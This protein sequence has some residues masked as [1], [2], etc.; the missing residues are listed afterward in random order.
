MI[1]QFKFE[2]KIRDKDNELAK[3]KEKSEEMKQH[4]K[5]KDEEFEKLIDE[6]TS[7]LEL[8]QNL[9]AD[10]ANL[11]STIKQIFMSLLDGNKFEDV[12]KLMN[13]EDRV[14]FFEE[15]YKL[16]KEVFPLSYFSVVNEL[17]NVVEEKDI[18][19]MLKEKFTFEYT[20]FTQEYTL[21]LLKHLIKLINETYNE[22][23]RTLQFEKK[24]FQQTNSID[25]TTIENNINKIK[26]LEFSLS[27]AQKEISELNGK[28][29]RVN[30]L[31]EE[32]HKD[33]EQ[34]QN[35]LIKLTSQV[36]MFEI[37]NTELHSKIKEKIEKEKEFEM[38]L[39]KKEKEIEEMS[40]LK[41]RYEELS[42]LCSTRDDELNASRDEIDKL[43]KNFF[44][45][46]ESL[47]LSRVKHDQDIQLLQNNI[48]EVT[49]YAKTLE[50]KCNS[51]DKKEE[52]LKDCVILTIYE[53]NELDKKIFN[54]DIE[55][56]HLKETREKMKT[57]CDELIIKTKLDMSEKE[58]LIDKRVISS[59]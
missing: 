53:K 45:L 54:M 29:T 42:S 38:K 9:Q 20:N 48:H 18:V 44:E 12:D 56:K 40:K 13:L 51:Y 52:S 25:K 2:E 1:E 31:Y 33:K 15:A 57:Y 24:G 21:D 37:E 59:H 10:L 22:Q 5:L 6:N 11:K 3:L 35:K 27:K 26:D 7:L 55:L 50:E 17:I 43:R 34:G 4:Y 49:E 39:F 23:I 30:N 16:S 14:L 28:L 41:E 58:Y 36:E 19:T 47:K 32:S 8:K 46:E